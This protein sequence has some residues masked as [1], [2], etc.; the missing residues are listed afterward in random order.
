MAPAQI[1][2]RKCLPT[3]P[4]AISLDCCYQLPVNAEFRQMGLSGSEITH[5]ELQRGT[6]SK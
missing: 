2:C 5:E 4:L 6:Q 3:E 1:A